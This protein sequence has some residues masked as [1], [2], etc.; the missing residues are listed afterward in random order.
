MHTCYDFQVFQNFKD[1]RR[2]I[3]GEFTKAFPRQ[4]CLFFFWNRPL[5]HRWVLRYPAQC[6]GLELLH[7]PF[8]NKIC[9]RLHPKYM[10]VFCF[11][12]I[13]SSAI[14]KSLFL[15]NWSYLRHFWY[16]EGNWLNAI[17]ASADIFYYV[18]I[19]LW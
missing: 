5:I 13:C 2:N 3:S 14:W 8:Q 4:S 7:E 17:Q 18:P 1:K 6:T 19:I 9:H 11:P 10:P 12:I 15:Q 16:H